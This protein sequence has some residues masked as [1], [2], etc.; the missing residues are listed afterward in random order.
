MRIDFLSL[1]GRIDQEILVYRLA[2]SVWS[3]CQSTFW[4]SFLVK[5]NLENEEIQTWIFAWRLPVTSSIDIYRKF[6]IDLGIAD[7]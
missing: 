3:V 4:L 5:Q 1:I 2:M 6:D 7:F